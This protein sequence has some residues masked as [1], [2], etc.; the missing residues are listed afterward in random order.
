MKLGPSVLLEIVSIVQKGLV[1]R[2]DISEQL[3][4][5]DV[6]Q[7]TDGESVRLSVKYIEEHPDR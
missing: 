1:Q 4:E 6:E 5:I 7:E 2:K 3:R